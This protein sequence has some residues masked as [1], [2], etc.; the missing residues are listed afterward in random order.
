MIDILRNP[1][2]K[3]GECFVL[4]LHDRTLPLDDTYPTGPQNMAFRLVRR[5][6]WHLLR[7]TNK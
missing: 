5:K 6:Y 3:R 2:N 4:V 7:I 1:T